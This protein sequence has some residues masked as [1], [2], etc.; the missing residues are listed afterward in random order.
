MPGVGT[1]SGGKY[2]SRRIVESCSIV[3]TDAASDAGEVTVTAEAAYGTGDGETPNVTFV[4]EA[5]VVS[6]SDQTASFTFTLRENDTINS[7][8]ANSIE[9]D[10]PAGSL[11][12]GSNGEYTYTTGPLAADCSVTIKT[13]NPC[14]TV[15][16]ESVTFTDVN[17]ILV[18]SNNSASQC[19]NC[20][21]EPNDGGPGVSGAPAFTS[22]KNSA[23]SY[24][25]I[26]SLTMGRGNAIKAN[27]PLNSTIYMQISPDLF[28]TDFQMPQQRPALEVEPRSKVC[29]WILDGAN[30]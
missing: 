23:L 29:K 14:P 3:L 5:T 17:N 10:C 19:T 22:A 8:V 2:T 15:V 30:N 4:S 1:F 21:Y 7:D 25:T 24:S 18:P 6:Q 20:H 12:E 16:T 28:Y 9:S 11:E 26:I 13:E 27:D